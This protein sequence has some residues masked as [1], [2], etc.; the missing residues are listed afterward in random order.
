MKA[1]QI[2]ALALISLILVITSGCVS[3][4]S[5]DSIILDSSEDSQQ[6][7]NADVIA[8]GSLVEVSLP[9]PPLP[10][11][12]QSILTVHF[13]DVG[14]GDS[15]LI[16]IKDKNMLIDAGEQKA[17]NTVVNYLKDNG[18]TELDVIVA[19]HAHAD[20][21]GGMVTVLNNFKVKKFVDSGNP[22]TTKTYENMLIAIDEKDIPFS[23]AEAGQ[24]IELDPSLAIEIL[25]P[26]KPTGKLNDDSVVLKLTYGDL[27]FLF[28]GDTEI[29]AEKRILASGIDIE[30][31]ILKV[32]H[33]GSKSSTSIEFLEKVNPAAS[34]IM[35]GTD[36][37]YGHPTE[38]VI[39]RLRGLGSDIYRTDIEGHIVVKTDGKEY[40]VETQNKGLVFPMNAMNFSLMA[41]A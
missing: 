1:K 17:G 28:T 39:A 25:N 11:I 35:V 15:I 33:H 34:I 7:P 23:L 41:E 8:N 6:E 38:E 18:V 4:E 36:N 26:E 37:R 3:S 40:T 22:H 24:T 12:D 9:E 20:H 19:T 21:I 29:D 27:S 16:Q 32:A 30:S 10:T 2:L 5:F 31:Q 14:Q 13:I